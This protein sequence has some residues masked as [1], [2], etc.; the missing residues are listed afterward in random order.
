MT[1][2]TKE[3]KKL[4]LSMQ[5]NEVTEYYIYKNIAARVKDKKN[6][7]IL[8]KI[9]AQEKEHAQVWE[10]Y[11]NIKVKPNRMKIAFYKLLN[12][13]FGFTFVV[14]LMERGEDVAQEVYESLSESIPEALTIK[15]EE[16]EHEDSLIESLSEERLKYI[17][18]VVLGLNDALVE[19][20]GALAGLSFALTDNTIITLSGL[21]T[22]IAATLSMAASEYLSSKAEGN[23]NALKSSVYTGTAYLVVVTILILPYILLNNA[24]H[25]L[26]IM[27]TSA[28]VII[29][30][31][32]YYMSVALNLSFKK[33]FTQM[34]LISLGVA[35]LSFFIGTI[36]RITLGVDI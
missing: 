20:T 10:K 7:N 33:R 19:L 28:M 22:G 5:K 35:T 6:K 26:A 27:L 12:I 14:R 30:V 17:R 8:L 13:I 2:I 16:D 15:Q 29:F 3:Q 36:L 23:Q 34:A 11:T 4:I 25:S 9:A 24:F 31:F 18:A 21:I 32:N 1:T